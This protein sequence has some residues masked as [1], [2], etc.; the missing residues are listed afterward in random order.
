MVISNYL[1]GDT[2][3][4]K[5]LISLC[6]AFV[7]SLCLLPGSAFADE[8]N[9]IDEEGTE[10]ETNIEQVIDYTDMDQEPK[11]MQDP[12]FQS[13]LD[14][15]L[16][17]VDK[18][19]YKEE[20]YPMLGEALQNMIETS[21]ELDGLVYISNS[22][23]AGKEFEEEEFDYIFY[24]GY[25]ITN[26]PTPMDVDLTNNGT[27]YGDLKN[28]GYL[29]TW[30]LSIYPDATAFVIEAKNLTAKHDGYHDDY[31]YSSS[32]TWN[33]YTWG[34]RTLFYTTKAIKVNYHYGILTL[35]GITSFNKTVKVSDVYSKIT[36]IDIDSADG[37][38]S[39]L[40]A[41]G[42]NATGGS[43]GTNTT[44]DLRNVKKWVF[45]PITTRV[46]WSGSTTY[47]YNC[48]TLYN[49][50][51]DISYLD[52]T[53]DL[54]AEVEYIFEGGT[55]SKPDYTQH[56][57]YGCTG[58]QSVEHLDALKGLKCAN[59]MFYGCTSLTSTAKLDGLDNFLYDIVDASHMFY[60]CTAL[61]EVNIGA[62]PN[63]KSFWQMF[64]SNTWETKCVPMTSVK[65]GDPNNPA[66]DAWTTQMFVNC[67][68]LENADI[69]GIINKNKTIDDLLFYQCSKLYSV[70]VNPS[71]S[72]VN[73][74]LPV[75]KAADVPG[76]NGYWYDEPTGNHTYKLTP[77]QLEAH[78]TAGNE[79]AV[80]TWYSVGI[81]KVTTVL[82]KLEIN[83]DGNFETY[84]VD[85]PSDDPLDASATK[86][87]SD[88][89]SVVFYI[90]DSDDEISTGIDA[91]STII[92]NSE[93][94]KYAFNNGTSNASSRL[95]TFDEAK[96]KIINSLDRQGD[97]YVVAY[98]NNGE[99]K[100]VTNI[101]KCTMDLSFTLSA[102]VSYIAGHYKSDETVEINKTPFI[103]QVQSNYADEEEDMVSFEYYCDFNPSTVQ[104]KYNDETIDLLQMLDE[105]NVNILPTKTAYTN[106][107]VQR[108]RF[109]TIASVLGDKL[110]DF[111]YNDGILVE[112]LGN[113]QY[114]VD[115]LEPLRFIEA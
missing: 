39:G 50:A 106:K 47:E 103:V 115:N 14:E 42:G 57:F 7:L 9:Q 77:T 28:Y 21:D 72:F 2:N 70:T 87:N 60:G 44:Y 43:N 64:A 81:D 55:S 102:P 41:S 114:Y 97:Y 51:I 38:N 67:R 73:S 104:N 17:G 24:D 32:Y 65:V 35:T 40:G 6:I 76:A 34:V 61:A 45:N 3:K 49:Q 27:Y 18:D 79:T 46:N 86:H 78:Y 23:K 101:I 29:S 112:E 93:H 13:S 88:K 52:K 89:L 92:D 15:M 90:L 74:N 98:I 22:I 84:F 83:G 16:E 59:S 109:S 5:Q 107:C 99:N 71:F 33:D 4:I 96:D 30:G 12:D 75:I 63:C 8:L 31:R 54:T 69:S 91:D 105:S 94:K 11:D 80:K 100:G 108:I 26:I 19:Q 110:A 66:T 82:P 58:L 95:L 20:Y 53:P 62:M 36:D 111:W 68:N 1:L 56:L 37:N 85:S 10:E 25:D 113:V 48:K